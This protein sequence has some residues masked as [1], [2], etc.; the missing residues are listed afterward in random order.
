MITSD[1]WAPQILKHR[2]ARTRP[3][4][5]YGPFASVWA[6][7]RTITALQRAFLIRSCSDGFFESRTRPCLL[8]QIKRCSAPCTREID[9]AEY[10]ELVRE[11]NA[12]LSGKSRAVKE[13]LAAEMEKASAALDFERAAIYR[14]RLAA[15][16]AAH[17][18]QGNNP[19]GVEEA[20]GFAGH[21]DGGGF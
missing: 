17:A 7:N 20:D 3:G 9:F 8:H 4:H 5:Y 16:S 1:H 10:T 18:H 15:L 21:H 12:F 11:A 6:V 19:R 2:G 14:D 13:E